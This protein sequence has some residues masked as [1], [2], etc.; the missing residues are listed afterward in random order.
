MLVLGCSAVVVLCFGVCFC[1]TLLV[2]W[3]C[4]LFNATYGRCGFTVYLFIYCLLVVVCLELLRF[5]CLRLLWVLLFEYLVLFGS[6]S[7]VVCLLCI[8]LQICACWMVKCC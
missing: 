2:S 8:C 4:V 3:V 5:D 1:F 6:A 7:V